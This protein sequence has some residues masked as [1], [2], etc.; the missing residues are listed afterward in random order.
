VVFIRKLVHPD[1]GS[2]VGEFKKPHRLY[3]ERG[4][5]A[6]GYS[7]P[8]FESII[9]V[10]SCDVGLGVRGRQIISFTVWRSSQLNAGNM[11]KTKNP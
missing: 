9:L 11:G 3:R 5:F 8:K 2:K 1:T 4:Q 6:C 7:Y 10:Y